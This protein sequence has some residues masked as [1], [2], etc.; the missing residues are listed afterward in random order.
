MFLGAC[1]TTAKNDKLTVAVS[2]PPAETFVKAV[3]GDLVDVV[4]IIPPGNSPANYQR[5][6][7]YVKRALRKQ[8][9]SIGYGFV[10]ILGVCP[11][12]WHMKPLEALEF[13][14][15]RMMAEYPLGEFKNIDTIEP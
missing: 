8:I 5:T 2:I 9:D 15:K 14:E 4:T 7:S 10:E 12:D 13:L 11:T 1:Q 6:K 3:A